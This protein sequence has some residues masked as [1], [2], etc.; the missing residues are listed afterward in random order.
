[1]LV[2]QNEEISKLSSIINELNSSIICLTET[3]KSLQSSVT[4]HSSANT[5]IEGT[6]QPQPTTNKANNVVG[7]A[8]GDHNRSIWNR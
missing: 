6:S 8:Q 3:I 7:N 4:N 2:S 5:D 1:M